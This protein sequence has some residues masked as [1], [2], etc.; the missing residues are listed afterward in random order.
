LR[1]VGIIKEVFNIPPLILRCEGKMS[2]LAVARLVFNLGTQ[3]S[4]V[5]SVTLQTL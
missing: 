5:V 1:L 2:S 4:S 3:W